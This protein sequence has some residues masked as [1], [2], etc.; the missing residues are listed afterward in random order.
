MVPTVRIK[1]AKH[2]AGKLL[3]YFQYSFFGKLQNPNIRN[4]LIVMAEYYDKLFTKVFKHRNSYKTNL[5]VYNLPLS[6][7]R[8]LHYR[9]QADCPNDQMQKILLDL[10]QQLMNL[11][12][13]ADFH[14]QLSI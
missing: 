12:M 5:V 2:E 14:K 13:K 1:L 8:I 6:I 4:D 3:E 7:A 11:N 10:D 9:I